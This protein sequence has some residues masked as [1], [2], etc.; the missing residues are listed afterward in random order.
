[1]SGSLAGLS[2]ISYFFWVSDFDKPDVQERGGGGGG[3]RCQDRTPQQRS[4][5]G[6]DAC[7]LQDR[8]GNPQSYL[9]T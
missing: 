9:E 2:I 8:F 4:S 1:M 7:V 5:L 6:R 3:V